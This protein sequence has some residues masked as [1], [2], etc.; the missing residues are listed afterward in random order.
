MVKN[1]D[2]HGCQR[3]ITCETALPKI[4]LFR[5]ISESVLKK[6]ASL[7]KLWRLDLK[8]SIPDIQTN[9]AFVVHGLVA[10][11]EYD[12]CG[13]LYFREIFGSGEMINSSSLFDD[14]AP[15]DTSSRYMAKRNETIVVTLKK[16]HFI[17]L[18]QEFP[19]LNLRYIQH[20]SKINNLLCKRIGSLK[21]CDSKKKLLGTLMF[22]RDK[23][24]DKNL[25]AYYR[26]THENLAGMSGLSRRNVTRTFV[27]MGISRKNR[28][29]FCNGN[30]D[31]LLVLTQS[32]SQ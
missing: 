24:P 18:L 21:S 25:G 30:E 4:G 28:S 7:S 20:L 17:G 10:H 16:S 12:D 23:N 31:D 6:A 9:I 11:V 1:I 2:K 13:T 29:K 3:K 5:G 15:N 26:L 19:D 22:L 32:L 8:E 14:S 27:L